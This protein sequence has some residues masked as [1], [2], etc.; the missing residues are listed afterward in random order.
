MKSLKKSNNSNRTNKNKHF[1]LTNKKSLT[2]KGV[3]KLIQFQR[4]KKYIYVPDTPDTKTSVVARAHMKDRRWE[5]KIADILTKHAKEGTVAIDMGAYIGTHTLALVDAVGTKG[6]VYTFE[7]QPW[8][9]KGILKTL[10]K[11]NIKNTKVYNVGLSSTKDILRFCSDSS[12]SSSICTERRPSKKVWAE[13]YN[14][15][16]ITLDSLNI[17]NVSVM[18]VDV[19]GHELEAL[20]GAKNTIINSKPVIVLEVWKRR[21]QRLRLIKE[22]LNSINYSIKNISADDF[23]C[24]PK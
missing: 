21:G 12:G 15:P 2:K 18:K 20:K 7:P 22:F 6:K 9:Y 10:Q 19:E 1:K 11:N 16:V 5:P 14:I 17:K 4:S 23:I 3:Y 24:L 13:I 8:A